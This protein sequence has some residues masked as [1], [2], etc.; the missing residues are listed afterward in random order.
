MIFPNQRS[1]E[2][3]KFIL[4]ANQYLKQIGVETLPTNQI[5]AITELVNA[6]YE[7]NL[8]NKFI[9]VYPF[10]GGSNLEKNSLNLIDP[11]KYKISWAGSV[12]FNN[13]GANGSGGYGDTRIPLTMLSNFKNVHMSAYTRTEI[14]NT[15][16]SGRLI[17]V[18]TRKR[19]MPIRDVGAMEINF[20]KNSGIIGYVYNILNDK[21]GFGMTYQNMV[22][23]SLSGK[24]FII[25]NNSSNL[26]KNAKCYLN[27]TIFGSQFPLLPT[28]IHTYNQR[29]LTIFGNGYD[30]TANND[31]LRANLSFA[32]IG[33]GLTENDIYNFNKI[34][35]TFQAAMGRSAL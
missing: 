25:A 1:S 21:G 29:T 7:N 12:T 2:K 24:G 31:C 18:N 33:Y 3:H 20:N 16:G 13:F 15:V 26:L 27:G 19:L 17:G 10:A 6:L 34:V 5:G 11:L 30:N 28:E 22:D 32:S 8:W 14:S 9:A 35:E 4:V 23:N